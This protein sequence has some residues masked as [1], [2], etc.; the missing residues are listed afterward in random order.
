[1]I[2]LVQLIPDV[3]PLDLCILNADAGTAQLTTLAGAADGIAYGQSSAYAPVPAD[4]GGSATSDLE[5]VVSGGGC[6]AASLLKLSGQELTPA[7]YY[8]LVAEGL[9]DGG[10]YVPTALLAPHDEESAPAGVIADGG[11]NVRFLTGA[12]GFGPAQGG[13]GPIGNQFNGI[14]YD[15]FGMLPFSALVDGQDYNSGVSLVDVSFSVYNPGNSAGALTQAGY[16]LPATGFVSSAMS[17]F[18]IGTG[19]APQNYATLQVDDQA[20]PVNGL[21]PTHQ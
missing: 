1:M 4:F 16:D 19:V 7:S 3:G 9:L 21:L 6:G 14:F 15:T 2:R 13:T 12:I 8:T 11:A 20:N 5:I 18:F 17:L 10:P